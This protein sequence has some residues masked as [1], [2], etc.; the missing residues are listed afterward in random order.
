VALA[1]HIAGS[2][3]ACRVGGGPNAWAW[4]T[5]FFNATGWPASIII[6]RRAIYTRAIINADPAH[7]D[8]REVLSGT[9]QQPNRNLLLWRNDG[10]DGLKTG[11]PKRLH[12]VVGQKNDQR[13]IAAQ[14]APTAKLH[15]R[16][17]A[18]LLATASVFET[19]PFT[20]GAVLTE[21]EKGAARTG[22]GQTPMSR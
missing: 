16:K 15:V 21:A 18:K 1:E 5:P 7:C 9:S 4:A 6:R 11:I 10:V 20:K 3:E 22:Q 2:E 19:K 12:L 17:T 14:L 13:L 8:L